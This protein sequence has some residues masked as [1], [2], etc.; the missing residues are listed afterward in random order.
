MYT[1]VS[2]LFLWKSLA[3]FQI[4]LISTF[5]IIGRKKRVVLENS[6]NASGGT[7]MWTTVSPLFLW[8]SLATFQVDLILK[9]LNAEV[10]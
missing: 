1:T 3:T 10:V 7:Q 2:P 6:F 5:W 8:K 9:C 4:R